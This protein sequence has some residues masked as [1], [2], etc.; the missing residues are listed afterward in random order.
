MLYQ[1]EDGPCTQSFGIHVAKTA[2]FPSE[3]I[4]EA[5]RKA[6][7]LERVDFEV[8]SEQH[9]HKTQKMQSALQDF[10]H[11]DVEHMNGPEIKVR[12]QELFPFV[13]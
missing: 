2:G 12:L 6:H 11:L 7:E 5:K 9:R 3:V 10:S 1:L 13:Q 4:A 8:D